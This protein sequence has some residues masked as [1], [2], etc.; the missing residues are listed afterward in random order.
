MTEKSYDMSEKALWQ[1][2]AALID[3]HGERVGDHVI[4]QMR[5]CSEADDQEGTEFWYR[6]VDKIEELCAG[7]DGPAN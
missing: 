2:A 1:A 3:R 5:A 6:I 4:E 7:D